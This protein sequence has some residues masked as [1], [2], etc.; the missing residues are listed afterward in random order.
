MNIPHD[1]SKLSLD[2]TKAQTSQSYSI[3][4]AFSNSKDKSMHI[5]NQVLTFSQLYSVYG[6][7]PK[8]LLDEKGIDFYFYQ[9][10]LNITKKKRLVCLSKT[11][12]KIFFNL[13]V[14]KFDCS[15]IQ[16]K[17]TKSE[18]FTLTRREVG[19]VLTCSND[20][21]LQIETARETKFYSLPTPE[22][23]IGDTFL[24]DNLSCHHVHEIREHS[25]RHIR[26]SFRT[27]TG[28]FLL[29]ILL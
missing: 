29:E 14:F 21:L 7:I 11:S 15:K 10:I 16:Q 24:R 22:A 4:F 18:E 19:L 23:P 13:K 9:S 8:D 2:V 1:S 26:L 3:H 5:R 12:N 20:F 17:Y 6:E 28:F 25:K 27:K